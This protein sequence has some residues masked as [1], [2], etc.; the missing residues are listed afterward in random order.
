MLIRAG[1]ADLVRTL[2][3]RDINA[4]IPKI[5]AWAET[6]QTQDRLQRQSA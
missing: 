6:L 2:D 3:Q 5:T 1:A 4:A